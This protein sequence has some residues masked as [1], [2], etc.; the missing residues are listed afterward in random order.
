MPTLSGKNEHIV[1]DKRKNERS[2]NNMIE[3]QQYILDKI[4]DFKAKVCNP[5]ACLNNMASC[6]K[7]FKRMWKRDKESLDYAGITNNEKVMDYVQKF[8]GSV[9]FVE[10][11]VK[12]GH[13]EDDYNM[14]ESLYKALTALFK[15]A[16]NMDNSYCEFEEISIQDVDEIFNKLEEIAQRMKNANMRREMQD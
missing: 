5:E 6:D 9:Y 12:R 10:N 8:E 2:S 11:Y 3:L 16:Q 4:S 14:Y 13:V 7:E 15:M 1:Y